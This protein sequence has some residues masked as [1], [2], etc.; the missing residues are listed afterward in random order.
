[1]DV[2]ISNLPLDREKGIASSGASLYHINTDS[3][4]PAGQHLRFSQ[5]AWSGV[6]I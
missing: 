2:N 3:V 4:R 5:M 6:E 1:M